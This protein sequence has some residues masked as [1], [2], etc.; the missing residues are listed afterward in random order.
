MTISTAVEVDGDQAVVVK[1]ASAS[2]AERLRREGARL[3]RASHPGVVQVVRS[4]PL[5]DGWELRTA[6]AGRP[7]SILGRLPVREVATAVAAVAST[8]ADLHE[9]GMVHGRIDASHVLLSEQGRP[10]LCGF[11]DGAAPARRE[12][13]VEAVGELLAQLIS[14][15]DE[16]EPIPERRW[17]RARPWSGW[18]RR[19]LL[20]LADQAAAEP[21]TRRPTARRLAAAIAEVVPDLPEHAPPP[22]VVEERSQAARGGLI[23][24][25]GSRRLSALVSLVKWPRRISLIAWAAAATLLL[26]LAAQRVRGDGAEAA[27]RPEATAG[28]V[29]TETTVH[30]AATVPGSELTADGRRYRVGQEG[31]E[32]LVGDWN[33]DGTATPAL[34]RP[35]TGE[36]FVFQRWVERAELVVNPVLQ[37]DDAVALLSQETSSRCASLAVQTASGDLVPVIEARAR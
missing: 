10:V 35:T 18:D 24:P 19:G 4:G 29:T 3:E 22:S 1:Q 34:L 20:L 16:G 7:L 12:D 5:G 31:D 30:T 14:T 36:V 8:L 27:P 21:I 13:D 6:H 37:V 26:G 32:L 11:G 28:P 9:Q 15:E 25:M 33:C 2:H 23:D 17:R